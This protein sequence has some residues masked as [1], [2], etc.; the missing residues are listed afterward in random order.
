MAGSEGRSSECME[1]GEGNWR[2]RWTVLAR[3]QD[4]VALN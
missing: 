4:G 1:G 2:H 3:Y